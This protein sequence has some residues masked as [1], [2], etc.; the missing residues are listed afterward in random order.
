MNTNIKKYWKQIV[1]VAVLLLLVLVITK[2][3]GSTDKKNMS[4]DRQ[5]VSKEKGMIKGEVTA[6]YEGEHTL[7]YKLALADNATTSLEKDNRLLKISSASTTKPLYYYFS[8]E[9]S[10]GYTADDYINNVLAKSVQI[11]KREVVTHG[12]NNW[13]VVRSVNSSWYIATFGEWL[14]VIES[15]N[16]DKDIAIASISS[17]KIDKDM[18]KNKSDTKEMS[19]M[20]MI[21]ENQDVKVK[22]PAVGMK[23]ATTTM[24]KMASSTASVT[25]EMY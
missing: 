22:V 9:G 12:E 8:Y 3:M 25:R 1:S 19:D 15:S 13:T 16:A 2:A 14:L 5:Q 11:V 4:D 6:I 24:H 23:A 18:Q 7:N 10:R 17:F 20:P 21:K